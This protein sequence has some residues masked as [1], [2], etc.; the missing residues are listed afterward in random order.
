MLD[1][2]DDF[3]GKTID[4]ITIVVTVIGVAT[5]LGFR[6]SQINGGLSYLLAIPNNFKVQTIIILI[7]TLLFI[8][9]A[10]S[11]LGNVVKILSNLNLILAI[12]LLAIAI[13]V[14]PSVRIFDNLT[15]SL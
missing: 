2:T 7:T 1:N 4:I 12:G 15:N 10:M 11:G 13:V 5:T 9:S 14:G 3:I 6:A 8:L